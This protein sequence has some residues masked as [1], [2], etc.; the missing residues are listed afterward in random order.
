MIKN[1]KGLLINEPLTLLLVGFAT[2]LVIFMTIFF[3]S[4]A[5]VAQKQLTSEEFGSLNQRTLLISFLSMPV[6]DFSGMPEG[7]ENVADLITLTIENQNQYYNQLKSITT[8][9]LDPYFAYEWRLEVYDGAS[10]VFSIE[11]PGITMFHATQYTIEQDIP[12]NENPAKTYT[13]KLSVL[14]LI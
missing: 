2:G 11:D 4:K 1:K 12:N 8:N 7:I 5:D 3:L 10:E 13:I 14:H 6:K 9:K